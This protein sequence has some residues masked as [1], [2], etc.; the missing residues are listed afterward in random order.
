MLTMTR[1]LVVVS[2]CWGK[3]YSS[4]GSLLALKGGGGGGAKGVVLQ[5]N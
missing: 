4:V 5:Y 3:E 2:M 1:L